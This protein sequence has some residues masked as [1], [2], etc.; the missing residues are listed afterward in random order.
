MSGKESI[1]HTPFKETPNPNGKGKGEGNGQGEGQD[2][3]TCEDSRKGQGQV[4]F[5][6][7][8]GKGKVRIS[9]DESRNIIAP[10]AFLA[11]Q[12]K[13]AAERKEVYR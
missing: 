9:R 11:A 12:L 4:G 1:P 8:D 2:A 13:L 3:R 5:R 10:P 6:Q 7:T